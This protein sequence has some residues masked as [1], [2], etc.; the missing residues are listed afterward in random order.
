M[1]GP[2][3]RRMPNLGQ[4]KF[5]DKD[6][7]T[8]GKKLYSLFAKKRPITYPNYKPAPVGQVI[9]KESWIPKRQPRSSLAALGPRTERRLSAAT[10]S[11]P[12]TSILTQPRVTRSTRHRSRMGFS[13]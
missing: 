2:R 11:F 13:S 3:T 10:S 9:V 6:E 1:R 8:H 4:P 7:D 12:T 5:S